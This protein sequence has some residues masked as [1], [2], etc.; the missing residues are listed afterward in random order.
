MKMYK[1]VAIALLL[2]LGQLSGATGQTLTNLWSF[3]GGSD[4][5]YPL[6]WLAQ[7]SDG[8]LYGTTRAG[9]TNGAGTVFRISTGGSLTSLYQFSGNDG[10]NPL[11]GLVQG[12]DGVFYGTTAYGGTNRA[13][14]VFKITATGSLTTL[15]QFSGGSDGGLSYC[16]DWACPSAGVVQGGN[17]NFYGTTS[18]GG[19]NDN[20]TI[21]K[22][23]TSGTFSTLYS[24]NGGSNGANPIGGLVQ[25]SDSA[26]YGTTAHGGTNGGGTV[27][28]ITP[29]GSLTTL[30]QFNSADLSAGRQPVGALVQGSD[31]NF[32][33]TTEDGGTN[34]AGTVYRITSAGTLTTLSQFSSADGRWPFGALVQGSDGNFYGTTVYG[35]N[36]NLNA[37]FGSGTIF[38]ISPSGGF[39]N[40]YSFSGYDGVQP[41]AALVQGSD[42]NFYGTTA[43]DGLNGGGTVFRLSVPLN[44]G[45]NQISAI[46]LSGTNIIIAIPSI[47]GETYQLQ[48]RLSL[49]S[50]DWSN[51]AGAS[52]TNCI[53]AL[54]TMTNFGA[55]SQTQGFYRLAITP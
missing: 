46:R 52:V 42:G 27:F 39:T 17:G 22:I 2:M 11:A 44:P 12:N 33:G 21:F 26:F 30:W 13:G 23:S 24:F 49:T 35:G 7:G 34:D 8:N 6:A 50:G 20:G 19:T 54:M 45:P 28:K 36:T 18:F 51:I 41:Y 47:A 29:T 53:G 43:Q 9:G 32:Y 4:G 1:Q 14:T 15:W 3:A 48:H 16:S 55:A 31:G 10:A 38:R 5:S 40:L 25:G 37:G